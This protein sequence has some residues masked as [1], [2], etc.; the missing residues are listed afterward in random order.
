MKFSK[1]KVS[2]RLSL[3]FGVLLLACLFLGGIGWLRMS[4]LDKVM[5][6]LATVDAQKLRLSLEMQ[7]RTRANASMLGQILMSNG[8]ESRVE[9]LRARIK[10]NSEM[11]GEA[12]TS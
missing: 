12:L 8:D 9:S 1:M 5:V 6:K 2:A 4:Q 10:A 7:V 11:N 3:G